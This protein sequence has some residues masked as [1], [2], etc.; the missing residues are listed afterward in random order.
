MKGEQILIVEDQRTVAG[1]MRTRLHGLGYGVAGIAS[2]GEEA[3]TKTREL[4]PDLVLMDI[5]LGEGIDGIEAA[6]QIK[7]MLDIPVVYVSA[8]ADQ[9]L[10]NRAKHTDPA[11][12]INKPFTSKDLLT[13]I[14]LALY[15]H[16]RSH[17]EPDASADTER[18][19]PTT[20]ALIPEELEEKISALSLALEPLPMGIIVLSQ[21]MRIVLTNSRGREILADRYGLK[22][23]GDCLVAHEKSENLKLQRLV[24][25]AA[26]ADTQQGDNQVNVLH[27]REPLGQRSLEILVMA[28]PGG[29]DPQHSPAAILFL[30]DNSQ[31]HAISTEILR[32]LY[33]L[34]RTELRLI[35]LL[36][37]G[38]TFEL[39]AREL[40]ISVNT[41]RTHLKHIYRKTGINRLTELI[42]RIERGPAALIF[43][44]LE[45]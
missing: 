40:R 12:F 3:V 17:V 39:C 43:K 33:R 9:E 2:S 37:D 30:F 38:H 19:A 8:Y 25:R 11:G 4:L 20:T 6:R 22:S 36:M 16:E 15:A 32:K 23:I 44:A 26:S 27:L 5:K 21:Q 41:V 45:K 34:T 10:I 35:A 13:T 42:Q 31:N 7:D 24:K 18:A 28:S 29:E 1:A 14:D